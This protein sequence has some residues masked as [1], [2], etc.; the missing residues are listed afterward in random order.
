MCELVKFD[1]QIEVLKYLLGLKKKVVFKN[2]PKTTYLNR[3]FN[4]FNYFKGK[5][6]YENRPFTEVLH[7]ADLFVFEVVSSSALHEAMTLTK[8]PIILL[9]QGFPFLLE[10]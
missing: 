4:H 5:V 9:H 6:E 10:S 2:Y 1:F 3:D 7:Q 8:T